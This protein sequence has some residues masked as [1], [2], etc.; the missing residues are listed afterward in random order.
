MIELI[1]LDMYKTIWSNSKP[2]RNGLSEFFHRYKDRIFVIATDDPDKNA[3]NELLDEMGVAEYIKK[4]YTADDMILV[5]GKYEMGKNLGS[6][7]EEHNV[8]KDSTIFIGDGDRDRIDSRR[9]E[10]R[11]IHVPEYVDKNEKFSFDMIDL[12]NLSQKYKDF[13][14]VNK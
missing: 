6:I 5:G 13:R 4:I 12:E 2:I 3:V 10:I 7:C 14:A 9:E 1:I 8:A 11:F